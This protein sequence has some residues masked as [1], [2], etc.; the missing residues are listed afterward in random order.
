MIIS[1]VGGSGTFASAS[2]GKIY[3]FNDMAT[4]TQVI[5]P[6]NTDRRKIVFHNPGIVN[7]FVAMLQRNSLT[8]GA[9]IPLVPTTVAL[10]GCFLVYADGGTLVV[11]G[12]CQRAW[13][14]FAASGTTNPLTV[15][16]SNV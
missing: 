1:S 14:G 3:A 12:E 2:G 4:T 10:G 7:I 9:T 8:T 16:D 13:L 15:M 6:F 11:E 5:A